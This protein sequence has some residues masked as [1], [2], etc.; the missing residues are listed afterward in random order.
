[1]AETALVEVGT[2][3][4]GNSGMRRQ[5]HGGA[6]SPGGTFGNKGGGRPRDKV[7]RKLVNLFKGKGLPALSQILNA[8][9][10]VDHT[11]SSCGQVDRVTPPKSDDVMLKALEVAGKYGLGTYKEIEEHRTVTLIA[12][13]P[14]A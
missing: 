2:N 1:M 6:L 8:A 14:L 9:R 10:T 3:S 12:P 4:G 7:R 5:A 13:P 11:C